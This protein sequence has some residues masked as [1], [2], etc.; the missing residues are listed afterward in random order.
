MSPL[1]TEG[2]LLSGSQLLDTPIMGLQT[3]KELAR[4]SSA[5]INPHNL[6]IIAYG[7]TGS[8][9]DH[10]PSY[11]RIADIREMGSLGMI[12]D[13][14]D[15]FIEPE[16]II[17]D[18]DIYELNFTLEG[19]QVIDE[20]KKKIGKVSDYVVDIDSFVIQQLVVKKP[21][22]QSLNDDELLIHRKQIIEVNDTTII[23][24]SSRIKGKA[25]AVTN[26]H[27]VNPFRQP[28]PQPETAHID[29]KN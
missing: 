1:Y 13:S 8:H 5:V 17:T 26:R 3:G 6:T 23:I 21:L 22:L 28:A 19:K 25:E 10:D 24:K 14:S 27:Y 29:S 9:L 7:L 15:E 20:Q 2:M 16:D 18:K 12:V 11:L 4:T